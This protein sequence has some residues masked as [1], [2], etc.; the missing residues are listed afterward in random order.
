MMVYGENQMQSE[1]RAV[2]AGMVV[3]MT[4]PGENWVG[5]R[6]SNGT[7]GIVQKKFL[8]PAS[9]SEAGSQFAP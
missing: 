3:R 1:V 4:K 8:R 2:P 7:D 9:A 5:I 6:L